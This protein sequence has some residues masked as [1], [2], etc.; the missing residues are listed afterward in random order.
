MDSERV[1]LSVG[2]PTVW[3]ALVNH[4]RQTGAGFQTLKRIM[5]GGAALPRALIVAFAELGVEACQ[6]WG[7]TETSP[8]VAYNGPKP[9]T[10]MLEGEA[11][12]DHA[13]R[14]GRALFGA[15][16]RAIGPDGA[17]AP[18]DGKSQG[19]ISCRGHWIAK[20]YFRS[21]ESEI[22]DE[23]WFPTGDV[24]VI[25]E[26]GFMLLTDRSKD[27]IKSGGEWISSIELENIAIGHPDVA[28]AAAIAAADEKWGERP[29][30]IVVPRQ[31][32][33][34]QP[35]SLR[36]FFKGK[37]ANFAIPDRVIVADELPHGATG[38]ILKHELRRLYAGGA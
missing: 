4:M 8:V 7:M 15:D 22:A 18:W 25:D 1:D 3:L 2:V 33:E 30:L 16:I 17:E 26:N 6:G 29:L 38:K 36:A 34:P 12:F 32:H 11:R 37:V 23:A 19:D 24:G 28:E 20:G 27:L 9:A 5:S 13:A 21:A 10:A 31:G 35:E 14:Q